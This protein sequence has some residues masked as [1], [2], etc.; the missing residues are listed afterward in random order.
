MLVI[1][2]AR[3]L[4]GNSDLDIRYFLLLIHKLKFCG[5][6]LEVLLFLLFRISDVPTT[7][8][9]DR[10]CRQGRGVLTI[11]A[12]SSSSSSVSF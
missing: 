12:L 11:F 9:A 7:Q 1:L 3:W 4:L 2:H 10:N 6:L 5:D 8:N